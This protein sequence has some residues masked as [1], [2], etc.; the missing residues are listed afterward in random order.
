M[1]ESDV[2]PAVFTGALPRRPFRTTG[3]WIGQPQEL[4][5]I[6]VLSCLEDEL[7]YA[8]I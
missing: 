1:S 2:V 8:E 5:D 6:S 4:L 7:P 3:F